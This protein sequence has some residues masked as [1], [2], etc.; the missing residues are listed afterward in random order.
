MLERGRLIADCR[1]VK[2]LAENKMYQTY[3]VET[4][5]FGSVVMHLFANEAFPDEKVRQKFIAAAGSLLGHALPGICSLL[6]V[7]ADDETVYAL[8]PSVAGQPLAEQLVSGSS[9]RQSLEFIKQLAQCL[10]PA[11]RSGLWHGNL[12]PQTV[13][14]D[15]GQIELADFALSGLVKLDFNSGVDASYSS[16]E[17]VRGE[18]LSPASDLYS[19]GIILFQLLTGK[20]PY[21]G[22]QPFSI[23]M[24]HLQ[25]EIPLLPES[26]SICQPLLDSL[27][28]AMADERNSTDELI[29][30]L[31]RLLAR[32]ELDALALPVQLSFADIR[33]SLPAE[34]SA[35]EE[36]GIGADT[37]EAVS[38]LEN[39]SRVEQAMLE[40]D[41]T[42]RIERRLKERAA[43]LQSSSQG[44]EQERADTAR[45]S[46]INRQDGQVTNMLNQKRYQKKSGRGRLLLL[47][48]LGIAIGAVLYLL[49]FQR[50][51][52]NPQFA[53]STG[54][55][56]LIV[57]LEAGRLQLQS[58]ELAAAEKTFL[59]L[60][61]KYPGTPEPYNNLAVVYALQGQLDAAKTA[62]EQALA[63]DAGY[64]TVYRNLGTVYAEM[65]RDSYGRALQLKKGQ[66]SVSLL[67]FAADGPLPLHLDKPASGAVV[68]TA[69][70]PVVSAAVAT[71]QIPADNAEPVTA[72]AAN[73]AETAP[74]VIAATE[75]PPPVAAV[76]TPKVQEKVT[77]VVIAPEPESA[78]L[79]L[80]SW[81][82]AWAAQNVEAYL[83][84][85]ADDYVP[86]NGQSRRE[87]AA[88]RKSRLTK[89]TKIEVA[90]EDFSPLRTEGDK[91]QIEVTQSYQSD[92][93]ADRTRKLFDLKRTGDKWEILRER[94]L[95]RVR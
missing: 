33:P 11:H 72:S 48:L 59:G 78:E 90:L 55:A 4:T 85:Y 53:S 76:V 29:D 87:W 40:S 30:E 93:F 94:S 83:S 63:T 79:F 2:P 91:I 51:A 68:A 1:I 57:A 46:E 32:P 3:L 74:P 86:S 43:V 81:A 10:S 20:L 58:D 44:S 56:E 77:E 65:A 92:R 47:T 13:F 39:T 69:A 25:G 9:A 82:A 21:T 95:G 22:D 15:K 12:S 23:A 16:P 66:Q 71:G 37:T 31:D 49:I 34:N 38:L 88:G 62:L 67:M 27:L 5:E 26:L 8:Y 60:I 64:A 80:Q 45:I 89:P 52:E 50:G 28:Q 42:A 17:L 24:Q 14:I 19:I 7:G 18:A 54:P 61:E 35:D 36:I 6:K 75:V 84:F 70:E 41:V 73:P